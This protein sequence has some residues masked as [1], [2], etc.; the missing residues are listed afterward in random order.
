MS[1]VLSKLLL[2]LLALYEPQFSRIRLNFQFLMVLVI[3]G[4]CYSI[5]SPLRLNYFMS[6]EFKCCYHS[7]LQKIKQVFPMVN[8]GNRPRLSCVNSLIGIFLVSTYLCLIQNSLKQYWPELSHKNFL[9]NLSFYIQSQ[10][11]YI[12]NPVRKLFY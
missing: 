3:A 12:L 10:Q 2:K 6:F 8:Q 1:F 9:E 11:V 7:F 5:F 4:T